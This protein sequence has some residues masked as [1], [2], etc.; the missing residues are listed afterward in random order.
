MSGQAMPPSHAPRCSRLTPACVA[1]HALENVLPLQPHTGGK[2]RIEGLAFAASGQ[3]TMRGV[4]CPGPPHAPIGKRQKL[5]SPQSASS[6][7]SEG[8]GGGGGGGVTTG[9]A[10]Q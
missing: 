10:T 8:G 5:P 3:S 9:D 4:H 1:A 6:S 7:Q 2:G